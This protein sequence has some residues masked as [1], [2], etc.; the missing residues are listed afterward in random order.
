MVDC[1]ATDVLGTVSDVRA[2]HA[3]YERLARAV[4]RRSVTGGGRPIS[5]ILLERYLAPGSTPLPFRWEA[6]AYLRRLPCMREVLTHHRNVYLGTE[7]TRPSGVWGGVRPRYLRVAGD[8]GGRAVPFAMHY[9]SLV[10]PPVGWS[11]WGDDDQKDVLFGLGQGWQLRTD[12]VATVSRSRSTRD[13]FDVRFN[14]VLVCVKDR[15]DFNYGEHGDLPNPDAGS[16]AEGAICPHRATIDVYHTNARRMERAHLAEAYDHES[17]PWVETF[18]RGQTAARR[19][20][21]AW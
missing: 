15:Y 21:F 11:V 18:A 14:S 6:P 13:A 19:P 9:E 3:W 12:V 7:P 8:V 20:S 5:A 1:N 4:G 10:E 2:V 16:R 17:F